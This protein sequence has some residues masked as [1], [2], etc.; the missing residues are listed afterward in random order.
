VRLGT[1]LD[2]AAGEAFDKT[3]KLLG[4]GFPGGAAIE[5]LAQGGDR[6]RF[7]LPRPMLGQP[8]CDFSFSGL[9]TAVRHALAALGHPPT[10]TEAADLAASFQTAAVA[11]LADRVGHAT[12]WYAHRHPNALRL[13]VAGGVAANGALKA[14]LAALSRA[15][16][17]ALFVP[18]ARL[19]TDNGAMIAWAGAE[20]L[21]RG[22]VDGL[23]AGAR[24]RW[25]LDPD[26]E[27]K[28][29]A[30]VKA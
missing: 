14:E 12:T 24:A 13:V 11:S 21:G 9:K 29:Y 16:G 15:R 28:P 30:G 7:A 6:R 8:G 18:P 10:A 26:A 20:R 4:L 3:A 25:P 1:T 23:D 5:R 17:F 27:P 22:M 19:C 2:D